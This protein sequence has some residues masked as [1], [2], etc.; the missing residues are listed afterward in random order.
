MARDG[1]DSRAEADIARILAPLPEERGSLLPEDFYATW[2]QRQTPSDLPP[3]MF[4]FV[5]DRPRVGRHRAPEPVEELTTTGEFRTLVAAGWTDEERAS[6]SQEWW[7]L[8]CLA[9]EH[10]DCDRCACPCTLVGVG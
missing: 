4:V 10:G 6:L 7:C 9:N 8:S 1:A 2:T 5:E 3:R